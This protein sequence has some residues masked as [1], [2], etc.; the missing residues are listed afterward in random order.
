MAKQNTV[1]EALQAIANLNQVI[2]KDF[3]RAGKTGKVEMM[4]K[5]I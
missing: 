1:S 3:V 2:K 4:T 5:A